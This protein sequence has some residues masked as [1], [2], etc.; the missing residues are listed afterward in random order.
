VSITEQRDGSDQSSISTP[1]PYPS[2]IAKEFEHPRD[3]CVGV[4][5]LFAKNFAHH[6]NG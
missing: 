4:F 3:R 2:S 6:I 5:P 1:L